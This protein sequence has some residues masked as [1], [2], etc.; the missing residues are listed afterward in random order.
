M[1]EPSNNLDGIFE[2]ITRLADE[3]LETTSKST[4]L[5]RSVLCWLDLRRHHRELFLRLRNCKAQV[6]DMKSCMDKMHLEFMNKGEEK[7]HVL[8]ELASCHED[9]HIYLRFLVEP[10]ETPSEILRQLQQELE[11]RRSSRELLGRLDEDRRDIERKNLEIDQTTSR[12][13]GYVHE[14]KKVNPVICFDPGIL[15]RVW[16]CEFL[17][18]L[19]HPDYPNPTIPCSVIVS[20][21]Y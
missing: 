17:P 1:A 5:Q 13:I 20:C 4:L 12:Y 16:Y 8:K 10:S 7:L 18:P 19:S 15:E 3:C 11:D 6:N 2:Q 21:Q 14:L 9:E